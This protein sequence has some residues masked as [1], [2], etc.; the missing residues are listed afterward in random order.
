MAM[1][2]TQDLVTVKQ[3]VQLGKQ[4]IEL[5]KLRMGERLKVEWQTD[6]MPTDVLIPPLLL[7][8]LLENA[9]YHGIE[10]LPQGG[11]IRIFLRQSGDELRIT[12]ENPCAPRSSVTT[13]SGNKMALQNI[14][15]RLE[16]LFDVEARYKVES[17]DEWYR[18]EIT[19]PYMKEV[20]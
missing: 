14:R 15:E 6:A 7:Q 11:N 17:S 13:H 8:P 16:L 2:D 20:A 3:E 10:S 12:V 9:V 4:Y 19:L 1:A 5:E 18:V